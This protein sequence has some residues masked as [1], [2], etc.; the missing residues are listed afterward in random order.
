MPVRNRKNLQP[1]SKQD[2]LLERALTLAE[3]NQV[4]E[5]SEFLYLLQELYAYKKPC[6]NIQDSYLIVLI[7]GTICNKIS[8]E[9]S[10]SNVSLCKS[11]LPELLT[12]HLNKKG[13][14]DNSI[15]LKFGQMILNE[16]EPIV[17]SY[18]LQ[19]KRDPI[20][21]LYINLL[22]I[23]QITNFELILFA[24]LKLQKGHQVHNVF[25]LFINESS[26][27]LPTFHHKPFTLVLDLDETLG[28]FDGKRF[29]L[30]PGC[31][32]F[33]RAMSE[34][35]EVVLFTSAEENYANFAMRAVDI[36]NL[37]KLRLYRQHLTL[38]E[39]K[40]AK[41]LS[42]L[43]R[44]LNQTFIVDDRESNFRLQP[45]NGI[46]ITPWFGAQDDRELSKLQSLLTQKIYN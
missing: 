13:L 25:D 43:G 3:T 19:E 46:Q 14:S 5:G 2:E 6:K 30:R 21:I 8:H 24:L 31:H 9:K 38:H 45:K 12:H 27:F 1:K 16:L 11:L 44:N 29:L 28:H 26:P 32:E 17:N 15:I 35:F 40:P 23:V 39:G 34:Y 42:K 20:I 10:S 37:V 7:C 4:F 33:I 41:D 36:D 18:L 22:Q